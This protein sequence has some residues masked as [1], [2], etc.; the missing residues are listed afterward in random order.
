MCSDAL[1]GYVLGLTPESSPCERQDKGSWLRW[2]LWHEA[3]IG[4]FLIR[5]VWVWV[6]PKSIGRRREIK[7]TIKL[8]KVETCAALSLIGLFMC[9]VYK[10]RDKAR[11]LLLKNVVLINQLIRSLVVDVIKKNRGPI[12]WISWRWAIPVNDGD[13]SVIDYSG[14]VFQK[15]DRH[16]VGGRIIFCCICKML[17]SL[18]LG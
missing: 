12:Y 5:K 4:Y 7:S 1:I 2:N 16:E 3:R 11:W 8:S 13:S 18:F 14:G 17:Q 10:M 6:A 15:I 9:K